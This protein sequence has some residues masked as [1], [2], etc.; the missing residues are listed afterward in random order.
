MSV[1]LLVDARARA[2]ELQVRFLCVQVPSHNL[3]YKQV[4]SR[5]VLFYSVLMAPIDEISKKSTALM[6][7]GLLE[8]VG[9]II[10]D[11]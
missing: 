6:N 4:P 9:S 2:P 8:L 10:N 11:Q 5:E 1:S 3:V 7:F